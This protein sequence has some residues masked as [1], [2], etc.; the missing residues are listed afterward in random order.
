MP[1]STS[2]L[3]VPSILTVTDTEVSFVDRLTVPM[4]GV[5]PGGDKFVGTREGTEAAFGGEVES[6]VSRGVELIGQH[7]EH[8][9]RGANFAPRKIVCGIA[10]ACPGILLF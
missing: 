2:H 10:K 3:P 8:V 4:R 1:V 6:R 9:F 7:L 5:T